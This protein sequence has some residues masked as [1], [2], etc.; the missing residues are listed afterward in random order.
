MFAKNHKPNIFKIGRVTRVFKI[1]KS[2]PIFEIWVH[3]SLK[4]APFQK[5]FWGRVLKALLYLFS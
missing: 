4:L 1:S 5:V 3:T 2:R